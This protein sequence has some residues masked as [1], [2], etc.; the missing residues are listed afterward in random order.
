MDST[1]LIITTKSLLLVEVL[2][3]RK[4]KSW[5]MAISRTHTELT[6]DAL[7]YTSTDSTYNNYKVIITSGSFV[8]KKKVMVCGD[9]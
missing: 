8:F 3:S 9:I 1:Y 6:G 7:Q 2:Y 5:F 4:N